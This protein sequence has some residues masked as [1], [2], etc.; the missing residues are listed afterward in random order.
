[1]KN[2]KL[3]FVASMTVLASACT[4][5]VFKSPKTI[6]TDSRAST[7]VK[8]IGPVAVENCSRVVLFFIPISITDPREEYDELLEEAKKMG[9]NAV[10]DF[11][12]HMT[13]SLNALLYTSFCS[14]ATGTAARID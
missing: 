4:T 8:R 14:T 1:M 6:S 11:Q 7:G 9:G 3:L 12:T 2:L 13:D 5:P 10:V